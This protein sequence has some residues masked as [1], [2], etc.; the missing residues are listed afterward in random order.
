MK[1]FVII[2]CVFVG[3]AIAQNAPIQEPKRDQP[4][5]EIT[6]VPIP[7]LPMAKS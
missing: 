4:K 7:L 3:V 5:Y 2:L 1:K 6:K